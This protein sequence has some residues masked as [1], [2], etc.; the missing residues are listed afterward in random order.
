MTTQH[1]ESRDLNRFCFCCKIGYKFRKEIYHAQNGLQFC[2]ITSSYFS[3]GFDLLHVRLYP[4]ISQNL[5]WRS[6]SICYINFINIFFSVFNYEFLIYILYNNI[7]CDTYHMIF[8]ANEEIVECDKQMRY[9]QYTNSLF[10]IFIIL[11][12]SGV[13][14]GSASSLTPLLFSFFIGACLSTHP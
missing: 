14:Q 2:D 9:I 1:F 12:N 5:T 7:I 11:L 8:S 10:L 13:I 4:L 6:R 3:Y